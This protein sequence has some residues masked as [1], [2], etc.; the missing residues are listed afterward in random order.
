MRTGSD[1][2]GIYAST[3]V[4]LCPNYAIDE[5]ELAYHVASIASVRGIRGLLINGHAGENFVLSSGEKRRIV[6]VVREAVGPDCILISGINSENSLEAGE[7]ARDAE[8]A[9]ADAALIF[10]P[11]SWTLPQGDD[12]AVRHH[13]AV[14]AAT[15]LPIMLYQAP[16][17]SGSLAYSPSVLERLVNLPRVAAIKE[18]SWEAARYEA[19][20]RLVNRVA[21]HV[22]VMPSGDEHLLTCF[23]LGGRGSQVSIAAIIPEVVVALDEAVRAGDLASARAAHEII[24]PLAKAI[25]GTPPGSRATARI[26]TCLKLLGRLKL[27]ATR[28]PIG[29]LSDA[30]QELLKAALVSAELL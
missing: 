8:D 17:G 15:A 29:V 18:G 20:L 14:L 1:F 3:I 11:F 26:K 23:I 12:V 30:E 27:D 7:D 9:G 28:P 6:E 24:Y 22:L 10:P 21:P 2:T 4:P 5:A 13:E 16:V 19:N 25:Y